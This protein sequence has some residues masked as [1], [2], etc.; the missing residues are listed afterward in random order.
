MTAAI[1]ETAITVPTDPFLIIFL[2]CILLIAA[3]IDVRIQKIPNLLTFPAMVV[4][5]AYHCITNG[6]D[7]LLFSAGGLALGIALFIIPYLMGGMGAGDAKLMGA[8]GALIGPKSI[9][10]ASLF[11]A[12]AGGIYALLLL[13]IS[14]KYFKDFITRHAATLKTFAFTGQL[15]PIPADENEKKPRLCYGLAIAFGTLFYIF[16]ESYGYRF[17]I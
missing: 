17:P 4:A 5:L 8:V 14:C 12:V 16:L 10:L 13:L 6:W 1:K 2:S 11:T 9:F 7:G 15:I 3:I